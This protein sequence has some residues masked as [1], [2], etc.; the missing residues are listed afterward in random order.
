MYQMKKTFLSAAALFTMAAMMSSCSLTMP[1]AATSNPVGAK[2]GTS[3]ATI[4]LGVLV[5][6][7]DASIQTAAKNGGITRIST[8][9]LKS[10]NILN[11]FG[12]H[13]CIVT[14]E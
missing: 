2:V 8:V 6:N 9:D 12:T 5:F 7:G 1:V 10:T 14:G 13:E 11:L 3:K 4:Y